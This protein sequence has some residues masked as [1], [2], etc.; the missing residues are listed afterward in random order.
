MPTDTATKLM[1]MTQELQSALGSLKEVS[2]IATLAV[3]NAAHT[4][5]CCTTLYAQLCLACIYHPEELVVREGY[6]S[7]VSRKARQLTGNITS[8]LDGVGEGSVTAGGRS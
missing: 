8:T 7:P 5:C 4:T 3:L 1:A 2:R 6:R